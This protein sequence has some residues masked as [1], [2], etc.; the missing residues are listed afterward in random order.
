[1]QYSQFPQLKH[2]SNGTSLLHT[3]AAEREGSPLP[4]RKARDVTDHLCTMKSGGKRE[5]VYV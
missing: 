1:M 5:H 4:L 2:H 3:E